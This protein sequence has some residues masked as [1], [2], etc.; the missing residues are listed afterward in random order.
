MVRSGVQHTAPYKNGTQL[1]LGDQTILRN[2]E[3]SDSEPDRA[4]LLDAVTYRNL[5]L[6]CT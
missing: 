6:L 1:R 3:S 5:D 2:Q 4:V